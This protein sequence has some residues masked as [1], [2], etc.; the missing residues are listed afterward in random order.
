MNFREFLLPYQLRWIEDSSALRIM[1]KG[2]Q[3]GITTA[4]AL[5]S[6]CK[7]AAE[8]GGLDVWVA[9][10]DLLTARD[11]VRKC[12]RWA[13]RLQKAAVERWEIVNEAKDLGAFTLRFKSGNCIYSLSS[14]PDAWVGKTGHIKLDEFA[15]HSTQRDLYAIAKPCTTWGGQLSI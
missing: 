7:A 3:I 4:D 1:E 6:V 5:D 2:R 14:S 15:V 13:Q 11:Y 10:R 8:D 9:S 12:K